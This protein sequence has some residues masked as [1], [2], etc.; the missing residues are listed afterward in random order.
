MT[1]SATNLWFVEPCRRTKS[2][3]PPR[4]T[5]RSKATSH[6]SLTFCPKSVIDIQ[7]IQKKT[8]KSALCIVALA[9]S[10]DVVGAWPMKTKINNKLLPTC[11]VHYRVGVITTI[12]TWPLSLRNRQHCPGWGAALFLLRARRSVGRRLEGGDSPPGLG[13]LQHRFVDELSVA[14]Q[15]LFVVGAHRQAQLWRW[16]WARGW[17]AIPRGRGC[18]AGPV[19][20]W[21]RVTR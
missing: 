1:C 9:G 10:I 15:E 13:G 6:R 5:T 11:I 21:R 18:P 19:L 12:L 16:R 7:P 8:M 2:F 4:P 17:G 3:A 20:R 14:R